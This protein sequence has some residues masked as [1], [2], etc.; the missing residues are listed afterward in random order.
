MN[1]D[2]Q[3]HSEMQA[4]KPNSEKKTRNVPCKCSWNALFD[5]LQLVKYDPRPT[6]QK[7][8][9]PLVSEVWVSLPLVDH[10]VRVVNS[11][12]QWFELHLCISLCILSF[13]ER[14]H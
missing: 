5:T 10:T 8:E 12:G 9:G 1:L 4:F 14:C 2:L 3:L 11:P 13:T 6:I 7:M